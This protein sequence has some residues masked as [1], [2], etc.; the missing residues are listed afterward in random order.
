M[1]PPEVVRRELAGQW[2]TMAEKDFRL[3]QHLLAEDAP[4]AEAIVFHCQQ[5]A[6]KYLKA[7]L[8][9]RETAFPKT[10]SIAQLLDLLAA[11]DPQV[12][13]AVRS[14]VALTPY[15][16]MMRYPGE[17]GEIPMPEAREAGETTDLV[18]R[19]VVAC[20]PFPASN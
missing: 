16:V 19:T 4:F 3:V 18:R 17:A 8:T 11:T 9:W 5:A 2:L 10:H 14:A 6:E 13:D 12:A 20:L 15:A 7:L 1:R